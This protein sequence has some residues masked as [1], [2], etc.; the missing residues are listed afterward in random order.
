[1][2]KRAAINFSVLLVIFILGFVWW[3]RTLLPVN[4]LDKQ[5]VIFT[6]KK[7]EPLSS[8]CSRLEEARL[9]KNAAAFKLLVL[10]KNLSKKIQAGDFRLSASMAASEIAEALTHGSVDVWITFPEGWRREEYAARLEANFPG[11]DKNQFLSL[12]EKAE[13]SLFPDT[14]LIP[15]EAT[16]EE[17]VNIL[18]NNF[19]KKAKDEA[20]KAAK[21]SGL[22]VKQVLTM[23]S[24]VEREA[25]GKDRPIVAGILLKRL[26]NNWPLQTDATIQYALGSLRCQ[27]S[28]NCDWWKPLLPGEVKTPSSY[29]TY[30]NKGLPPG[31]ICNASL[32]SIMAV[33]SPVATDYWFYLT[34]QEGQNHYAKTGGEHAANVA[35]YLL[36]N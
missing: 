13:G 35:K 29:N 17:I 11:F 16:T 2:L 18:L 12:T 9:V 8:V 5:S 20:E 27:K 30:E 6:V 22:T 33:A 28:L 7:G 1:M 24:I 3:Q 4:S 23:A 19:D 31:P 26:Q 36:S 25:R 10:S 34:D 14:Y 15:H 32:S 21:S